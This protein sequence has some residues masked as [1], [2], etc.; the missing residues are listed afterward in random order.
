MSRSTAGWIHV[1]GVLQT[2]SP[3]H[4]GGAGSDTDIDLTL[5]TDALGRLMIPGTSLS[6]AISSSLPTKDPT[7]WGGIDPLEGA[8]RITFHDAIVCDGSTVQRLVRNG[9]G[10]N[11]VTG[12][13]EERFF[14]SKEVAPI[15]TTFDF[16]CTLEVQSPDDT[17]KAMLGWIVEALIAGTIGFG[18]GTSKGLGEIVLVSHKILWRPMGSRDDLLTTLRGGEPKELDWLGATSERGRPMV[19]VEIVW[20]PVGAVMVRSGEDGG[21]IKDVPL[22]QRDTNNQMSVVLPGSSVKGAIRSRAELIARTVKPSLPKHDAFADQLASVDLARALFGAPPNHDDTASTAGR[23]AITVYDVTGGLECS[24]TD[25]ETIEAALAS[26]TCNLRE[27]F[28]T[29]HTDPTAVNT[30]KLSPAMRVAIDRWTGGVST[31]RLF[32]ALEPRDVAWSP[33]RLRLDMARLERAA[34]RNVAAAV[35]L[36]FATV[37]DIANGVVPLGFAVNRG[38]GSI[39]VTKVTIK[40]AALDGT[41]LEG[42][43]DPTGS[44]TSEFERLEPDVAEDLFAALRAWAIEGVA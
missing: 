29:D 38:L 7:V 21:K 28:S 42:F 4:V 43:A 13:A 19:E 33:I 9:V 34:P 39:K 27:Q 2:R 20:E 44:F 37:R 1:S 3:L 32:S 12:T 10:I 24:R 5:A 22:V 30:K 14:Y 16:A 11:R 36:L 18:A 17:A 15:G 26:D 25:W 8:S 35:A 40:G 41:V 23:S 6:G 31:N